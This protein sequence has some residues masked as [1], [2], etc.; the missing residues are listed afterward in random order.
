M[1]ELVPIKVKIGLHT[2]PISDSGGPHKPGEAKYPD[3]NSMPVVK[4]S[5]LDWSVYVDVMGLQWHYDKKC[6]HK[7]EDGTSPHGMQ[8]GVLI[9][10]KEF[11]DQAIDMFPDEISRLTEPELED[12]YDNRAH[13]HEPDNKVNMRALE[14][15]DV[16]VRSG[17]TL[18]PKDQTRYN[19]AM[20]PNDDT[21][22]IT[23]NK[24]KKW[25][26]FKKLVGVNIVQ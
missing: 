6:G 11:A 3:F 13:A 17:R 9:V 23:R 15:F 20:N 2:I 26:D 1:R 19:K 16:Q 8:W 18:S 22:G 4:G 12:F 10:P 5:G 25:A 24:R 14:E 21:P 7:E